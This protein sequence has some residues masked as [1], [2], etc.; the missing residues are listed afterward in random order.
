MAN[1]ILKHLNLKGF[2]T[3][4]FPSELCTLPSNEAGVLNSRATFICIV[5][6]ARI[7]DQLSI[8]TLRP[9]TWTGPANQNPNG[10]FGKVGT[11]FGWVGSHN[12]T[13]AHKRNAVHDDEARVIAWKKAD[14]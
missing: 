5:E 4:K 7:K 8:Y 13:V 3:K 2:E 14:K 10:F 6:D 12:S 9:Y 1:K 11:L